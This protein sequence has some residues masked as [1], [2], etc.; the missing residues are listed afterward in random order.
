MNPLAL[1][2]FIAISLVNMTELLQILRS[3]LRDA[4]HKKSIIVV[5]F[6]WKTTMMIDRNKLFKMDAVPQDAYQTALIKWNAGI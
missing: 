2:Y 5:A 6:H 3:F 4:H 1:L